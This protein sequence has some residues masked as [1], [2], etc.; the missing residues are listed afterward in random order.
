VS[1]HEFGGTIGVD[2]RDYVDSMQAEKQRA[3]DAALA[4]QKEAVGK[5]ELATDRIAA[6]ARTDQAALREEMGVRLTA[7]RRELEAATAAQKEAVLKA[8]K[9]TEL[10]FESVNEW[11]DQSADRERSQQEERGKLYASFV[12]REVADTQYGLLID[13]VDSIEKRL[14][15][16]MG[17]KQGTLGSRELLFS[18]IGFLILLAAIVSPHIG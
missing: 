16:M 13:R 18:V 10:R 9:A 12:L 6:T 8:E 4:A 3:L 15:V 2:W 14:D 7:L 11:R 1:N 17:I 5:A